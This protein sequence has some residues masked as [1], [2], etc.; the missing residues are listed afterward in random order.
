MP[1]SQFLIA[2]QIQLGTPQ[3]AQL[4]AIYLDSF[5]PYERADFSFL[6]QSTRAGERWLFTA[7]QND[8]VLGFALLVPFI[9]RNVHLLEYLAVARDARGCG[10]GGQLLEHVITVARQPRTVR[11]LLI[12][13]EHEEEGDAAERVVRQRRIAFYTRH[14]AR[15]V[16]AV[17]QYRA[18]LADRAGTMRLRLLWL[19]VMTDA[20]VPR[21]NE[22]RECVTGI[23]TKS[24]GLAVN[25]QGLH[26]VL[27]GILE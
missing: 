11:G 13:V 24:Y 20:A 7:T 9:A 21:G 1:K 15:L 10:I 2:R 4:R 18:P 23:F 3:S 19:P 22:L 14:G 8:A 17:P 6:L 16:D 25:D 12:E 5:P 27:A 26:A